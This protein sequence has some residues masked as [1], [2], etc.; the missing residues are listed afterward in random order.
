MMKTNII[1]SEQ[2][3]NFAE[4]YEWLTSDPK[5][6]AIATFVGK[7]RYSPEENVKK[8]F[9][10]HY[11]N[12]AE[13][14]LEK[15]V[16]QA[17]QQWKINRVRIIHRVGEIGVNE[18]IVFVGVSSSHRKDAFAATEYLMDFLK[19]KAPFW[20]KEIRDDSQSWIESKISDQN[21][22]LRWNQNEKK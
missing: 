7:V 1:I 16:E 15:L 12:M 22:M 21:A 5:D 11:P 20:K 4:E 8:L 13:K 2:D 14:E 3:F 17:R 6:G 10:E 19:T 18:Q 9:I